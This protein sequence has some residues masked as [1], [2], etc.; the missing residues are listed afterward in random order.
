MKYIITEQQYRFILEQK[1]DY[2]MVNRITKKVIMEQSMGG[3]TSPQN[4][5]RY[6]KESL[7]KMDPHTLMTI[8]QIGTAFI[9][10]VGPFIS[11][12][13]GL[14]DAAMYYNEGDKKTAGLVGVLSVIPGIGGLA[15]KLGLGKWSAKDLG[16]IGKKISMGKKLLPQEISAVKKIAKNKNLIFSEINKVKSSFKSK[17]SFAQSGGSK[18]L[19]TPLIYQLPNK[20]QNFINLLP[21]N[22]KVGP[23]LLDVFQKNYSQIKSLPSRLSKYKNNGS[24]ELY[25]TR[26]SNVMS[27]SKGKTI[28]LKELYTD[29]NLLK[30]ELENIKNLT[31]KPKQ[32]GKDMEV[33]YNTL[34]TE[35]ADLINLISDLEQLWKSSGSVSQKVGL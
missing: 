33:W 4:F 8:T 30:K 29:A 10:F 3:M 19:V 17:P 24:V 12:G 7:E 2:D 6:S 18:G 14:T 9:P 25:S 5:A 31:P 23:K 21:N 35:N 32:G 34:Y 28:N 16:E 13:I 20:V 1:S 26:L 15:S 22:I 27:N 11:A